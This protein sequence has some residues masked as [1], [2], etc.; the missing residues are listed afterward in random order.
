MSSDQYLTLKFKYN[1]HHSHI[2]RQLH[3]NCVSEQID[4]S[5]IHLE[6][7]TCIQGLGEASSFQQKSLTALASGCRALQWQLSR[8]WAEAISP[9]ISISPLTYGI[10]GLVE[11][12]SEGSEKENCKRRDGEGGDAKFIGAEPIYSG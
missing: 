4:S 3:Q 7:T 6:L 8:V 2:S 10:G 5:N 12:H 11:G 9:A 1:V